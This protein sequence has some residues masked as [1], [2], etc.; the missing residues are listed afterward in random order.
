MEQAFQDSINIGQVV[1]LCCQ[2]MLAILFGIEIQIVK[3]NLEILESGS[4]GQR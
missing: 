4:S 2:K 3:M 1:V